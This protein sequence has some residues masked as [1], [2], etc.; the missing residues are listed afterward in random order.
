M[1]QD[2]LFQNFETLQK[3]VETKI[4]SISAY[5]GEVKEGALFV[6]VQGKE[7]DGHR[8]L[9]EACQKGASFLLVQED[10]LVPSGF[11]GTVVRSSNTL[12]ALP[13][14]LNEFYDH[15]SKKLFVVGVTGTNGKTTTSYILDHVFNHCGWPSGVIGTIERR[16][17]N[18]VW[19]ASLTTPDPVELF[20]RL[21][22]FFDLSAKAVVMEVSSIALDQ[23][24]TDGMD[25]NVGV[26]TNLTQDHLDYHLNFESYFSAKKRLFQ[27]MENS[28][29]SHFVSLINRDDTFGQRLFK[30]LRGRR[31]TFGEGSSADFSFEIKFQDIF[32]TLFTIR[33]PD[34][35]SEGEIALTGRHNMYNVIGAVAVAV[36]AGFSLSDC[37]ASLKNFS[38]VPGRLEKITSREH[39]FQVFVDYAHTPS[40]LQ[41]A[42]ESLSTCHPSDSSRIITVFGCGGNRDKDKRG[43]MAQ[44]AA[45]LSHRVFLTS[46][47]P[48]H[49][50]PQDIIDDSLRALS[51]K[52]REKFVVELDRAAAIQ[53][54]IQEAEKG[55]FLLIAGKGHETVQIIGDKRHPFDDR[56]VAKSFL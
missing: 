26:F 45:H 10:S 50:D 12:K 52:D 24:R 39:P 38:G 20:Q 42:L 14:V 46:D 55:D 6:A 36:T 29:G 3:G 49:E 51:Q 34:D 21:Q 18:K 33:S 48:R 41:Q 16:F 19:P 2:F 15:I 11:T 44:V 31:Y 54:A 43:E 53:K 56:K 27:N 47:N 37:V 25:F 4:S 40:A 7:D 28:D 8:Y 5:S 23:Y 17:K 35:F 9:K 30:E 32:H 13:L 22:D 1:N